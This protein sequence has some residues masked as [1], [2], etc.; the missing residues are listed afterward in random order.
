MALSD[1][2]IYMD[3]AATTPVRP[4]VVRA[5]LPY[6]SESFGKPVQHLR[7]GAGEQGSGGLR[8]PLDSAFARMPRQRTRLHVRRHGSGQRRRQGVAVALRNIGNHV[9]TTA[10]EHHA[11]LHACHQLEQFG[12]EVTYLPV[13]EFGMVDPQDV[14]DAV[15]PATTVVSVMLAKQRDWLD[16]AGRRDSRTR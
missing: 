8:P 2:L 4:E 12:Y 1:R 16:R 9:I 10:I 3:H 5:M 14:A 11:V 13:D 6:F 7:V 15:T